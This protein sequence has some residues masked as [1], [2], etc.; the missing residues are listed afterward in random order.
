MKPSAKKNAVVAGLVAIALGYHAWNLFGKKATPLP[1]AG[2]KPGSTN[3]LLASTSKSSSTSTSSTTG[4]T[5]APLLAP[6]KPIDVRG[7]RTGTIL[8]GS[9]GDRS[10]WRS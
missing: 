3:S 1:A 5:G 10:G 9:V 2:S 4:T 7:S 8:A 6:E